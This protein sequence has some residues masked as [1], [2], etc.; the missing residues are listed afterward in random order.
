LFLFLRILSH[1]S[2]SHS[3]NLVGG[4]VSEVIVIDARESESRLSFQ[5]SAYTYAILTTFTSIN[6]R[7]KEKK[8][9]RVKEKKFVRKIYTCIYLN[10]VTKKKEKIEYLSI[11]IVFCLFSILNKSKSM[12]DF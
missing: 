12:K 8:W 6:S 2:S 3:K 1:L 9:G 11:L 5:K 4:A 7:G 10:S